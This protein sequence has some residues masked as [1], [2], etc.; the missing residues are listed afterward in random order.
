MV[1]EDEPTR[2]TLPDELRMSFE[3]LRNDGAP[4]GSEVIKQALDYAWNWYS[5]HATQRAQALNFFFVA[6]SFLIAGYSALLDKQRL[7]AAAVALLGAWLTLWFNILD[8]RNRKHIEAGRAALRIMEAKLAM[9]AA[10]PELAI[11]TRMHPEGPQPRWGHDLI[12]NVAHWTTILAFLAA[13]AFAAY[14]P[15]SSQ[16]LFFE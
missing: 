13:A 9:R 1:R 2:R 16:I 4:P 12:I 3:P 6:V 7:A 14:T 10:V 8:Y 15:H 11:V 5:S